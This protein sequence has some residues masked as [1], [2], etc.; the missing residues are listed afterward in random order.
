MYCV[1]MHAFAID[2][3]AAF[4]IDLKWCV[5][6]CVWLLTDCSFNVLI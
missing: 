2:W 4:G 1:C 5:C 6:V 3:K